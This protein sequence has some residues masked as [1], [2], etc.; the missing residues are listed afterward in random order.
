MLLIDLWQWRDLQ[1]ENKLF[2]IANSKKGNFLFNDQ[3]VLNICF[4][5]N[6]K[7]L[8]LPKN[9]N[10]VL[11][12]KHIRSPFKLWQAKQESIREFRQ[13]RKEHAPVILHFID[14]PWSRNACFVAWTFRKFYYEALVATP[15]HFPSHGAYRRYVVWQ[16]CVFPWFFLYKNLYDGLYF[17][18]VRSL[19][20]LKR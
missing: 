6:D 4:S 2:E 10:F 15:W 20:K 5:Q 13:Y 7:C 17:L 11:P 19:K 14:K 1:I 3:D 9:Y 8:A 16:A 12:F 18:Y